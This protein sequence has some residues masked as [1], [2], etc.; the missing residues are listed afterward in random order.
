LVPSSERRRPNPADP[1]ARAPMLA[2]RPH[3]SI[4]VQTVAVRRDRPAGDHLP[5]C[6]TGRGAAGKR[7]PGGTSWRPLGPEPPKRTSADKIHTQRQPGGEHDQGLR[8][9]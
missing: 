1:I 8:R 7:L 5:R 9:F 6:S 3:A 2:S 4:V